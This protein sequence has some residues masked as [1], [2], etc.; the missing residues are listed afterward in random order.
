MP[1]FSVDKTTGALSQVS[2]SPFTAG[3]TPYA[4]AYSPSGSFL[5]VANESSNNVSVFSVNSTTGAL[6]QVGGSPFAAGSIPYDVAFSS[7]GDLLATANYNGSNVSVFSADSTTGALSQVAGSPFTTGAFPDAVAFSGSSDLLA[8]ANYRSDNVSVY[9]VAPPTATISSPASG[10]TYAV[11]QSVPT[12]FSCADS[13]YGPGIKTCTDSNGSTTGTGA[14]VTSTAGNFTYKVTATSKDGQTATASVAYTVAAP[15]ATTTTTT[16]PST[17]TTVAPTSTT[18]LPVSTTL[19]APVPPLAST[20]TTTTAPPAAAPSFPSAGTTYP[21]GAIVRFGPQD[22]VFAGGRAFSV[23]RA[24]LA[25]LRAV[26]HAVVVG[27]SGSLPPTGAARP[28]TLVTS[29]SMDGNRTI[30]VVGTNGELYGFASWRQL[31]TGGFDPALVVTVPGLEGMTVAKQSAGAAHLDALSTRSD[32]AIV[33]SGH[34]YYVFAGGRAFPV[35][36][37]AA[38]AGVRLTDKAVA[39]EGGVTS[40]DLGATLASGTL[41]TTG[42]GVYVAYDGALSQFKAMPQLRRNGYGGTAAV[43]VPATDL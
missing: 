8:T 14:L 15:P 6:N 2:G 10:G 25:K 36:S 18:T 35:P 39:L 3:T 12:S 16:P 32:G 38:L 17:T 11:G 22:Y 5:A 21:N 9:M 13:T 7:S 4:V 29:Y 27:A 33:I 42:H 37:P 20:T 31:S 1:V 34:T 28:G 24:E 41:L 19:P 26:D 23:P 40:A 30:Y 43:P